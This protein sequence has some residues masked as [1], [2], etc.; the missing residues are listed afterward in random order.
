MFN[1][2]VVSA[3]EANT[4]GKTMNTYFRII[5]TL[6]LLIGCG[7]KN[8]DDSKVI[9]KAEVKRL[10]QDLSSS[11]PKET[12][13]IYLK[14]IKGLTSDVIV[15]KGK[16]TLPNIEKIYTSFGFNENDFTAQQNFCKNWKISEPW[17]PE[18]LKFF[19]SSIIIS[20][21]YFDSAPYT[22]SFTFENQSNPSKLLLF[23]IQY[24]VIYN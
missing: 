22:L 7:S 20:S 2:V 5:M 14:S 3:V 13:F 18:N 15:L 11:F 10:F 9:T 1:C 6:L 19:K 17:D 12:E 23:Y 21:R 16:A 8:S 24:K 4:V